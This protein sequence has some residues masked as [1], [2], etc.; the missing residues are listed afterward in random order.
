MGLE[1]GSGEHRDGMMDRSRVG[2]S[3]RRDETR[4]VNNRFSRQPGDLLIWA[5]REASNENP[6][7]DAF[8]S[9]VLP[10]TVGRSR[11]FIR[12]AEALREIDM[13]HGSD[14]SRR[15]DV[16][17]PWPDGPSPTA[18]GEARTR[19]VSRGYGRRTLT[20]P[21]PLILREAEA[22]DH[23]HPTGPGPSPTAV[24]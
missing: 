2:C 12:A 21:E 19:S 17:R 23:A 20:R 14:A 6:S 11:R 15:A 3:G 22:R 10:Y 9:S 13:R 5:T 1:P 18:G 24:R 16:P 4:A 8:A 7:N